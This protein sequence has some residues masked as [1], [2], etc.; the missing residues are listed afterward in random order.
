MFREL[1]K[2]IAVTALSSRSLVYKEE[3]QRG[4]KYLLF[5]TDVCLISNIWVV[6][7]KLFC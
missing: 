4:M 7:E 2:T 6:L 5:K 3:V 1:N